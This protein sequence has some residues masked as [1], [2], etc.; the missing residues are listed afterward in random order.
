[1][2]PSDK[3]RKRVGNPQPKLQKSS[4]KWM[5]IVLVIIVIVIAAVAFVAVQNPFSN[6]PINNE[7]STGNPVAVFNTSLGTFKVELLKDKMPITVNNF[8]KLVN[9]GFYDGMIFYRISD[10]FM[11]QAGRYFPD[12][13]EKFSSYGNIQFEISDVKHVDGAISM[14]STAAKAGGTA[15]FFICDGVQSFL[16]G[17][18]ASFGVT[19]EGIEI[20][21]DIASRPHDNSN[22]AGGGKPLTDIIINSITIE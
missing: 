5:Y 20:V 8:V 14:A 19:I 18:Y 1:M 10:N 13:T 6:K 2:S 22:P 16:D 12:G 3:P 11:I 15:E 17:N 4:Q 9:D 21:R 7:A